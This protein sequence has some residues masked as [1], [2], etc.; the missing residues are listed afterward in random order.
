M[1]MFLNGSSIDDST[2]AFTELADLAFKPR[3]VF[4]PVISNILSR[5]LSRIPILSRIRLLS[6]IYVLLKSFR[7]DSLYPAENI[8]AAL[9]EVFG[10]D[11]TILDY[12]YATSIGAR[13]GLPVATIRE[14]SSCIFTNYNGVG[15]R[16]PDQGKS[17][18]IIP[19]YLTNQQ[20]DITLYSRRTAM[21]E[22]HSGKCK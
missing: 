15:T 4:I 14:P 7:A 20:Q 10:K 21:G 13:V 9:Q 11:K 5:I 6:S 8:E 17:L 2:E 12:S 19:L 1:D 22:Y 16:D 3:Q 18:R